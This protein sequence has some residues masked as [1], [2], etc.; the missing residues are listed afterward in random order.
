VMEYLDGVVDDL[1]ACHP[2]SHVEVSRGRNG[3]VPA[4]QPS[5]CFC[6]WRSLRILAAAA[7]LMSVTDH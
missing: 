5:M 2:V 1:L 4:E 3:N 6:S 7:A